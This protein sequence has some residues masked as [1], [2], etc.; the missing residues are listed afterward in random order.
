LSKARTWSVLGCILLLLGGTAFVRHSFQR[1]PPP[2]TVEK[3]LASPDPEPLSPESPP[4]SE[5]SGLVE[6]KSDIQASP[7]PA[8]E[9]SSDYLVRPETIS[10]IEDI[11]RQSGMDL[12]K[13]NYGSPGELSYNIVYLFRESLMAFHR[14]LEKPLEGPSI[15]VLFN[16]AF[17]GRYRSKSEEISLGKLTLE[18]GEGPY[19]QAMF[20]EY[21]HFLFHTIYGTPDSTDISRLFYNEL[22][23][24]FFERLFSYYLPDDYFLSGRHSRFTE[25]VH[26]SLATGQA[27]KGMST[28]LRM[29]EKLREDCQSLYPYMQAVDEGAIGEDELLDSIDST[30]TVDPR[31]AEDLQQA[32]RLYYRT[33]R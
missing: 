12:E 16:R 9:D 10:L 5:A 1:E 33:H 21:Q 7:T 2:N 3:L 8:P 26:D 25:M 27:R 30:F 19:L 15:N 6:K 17:V 18:E 31:R 32:M 14:Y 20:H 22:A 11:I 29:M 23:A 13:G 4:Q 28:I 24:Y